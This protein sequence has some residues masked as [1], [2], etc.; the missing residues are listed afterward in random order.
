M[1]PAAV[2]TLQ[3]AAYLQTEADAP[4]SAA[5]WALIP[6]PGRGRDTF[7]EAAARLAAAEKPLVIGALNQPGFVALWP[8]AA[9]GDTERQHAEHTLRNQRAAADAR[10]KQLGCNDAALVRFEGWGAC[11]DVSVSVLRQWLGE[12]AL[13]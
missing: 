3:V 4:R 13:T 9:L 2:L 1:D 6:G 5:R 10:L 8:I 11:V 12:Y 7:G